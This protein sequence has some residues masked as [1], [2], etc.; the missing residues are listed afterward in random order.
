MTLE[1][2]CKLP[3]SRNHCK[4]LACIKKKNN[5]KKTSFAQTKQLPWLILQDAQINAP[6]R[7]AT[8]RETHVGDVGLDG[9]GRP[10]QQRFGQIIGLF[11]QILV[12]T[13]KTVG[14]DKRSEKHKSY[15]T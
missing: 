15:K 9:L 5:K 11:I 8:E 12:R 2:V 10:L 14:R 1:S 4:L 6:S 13:Q 3:H 7:S